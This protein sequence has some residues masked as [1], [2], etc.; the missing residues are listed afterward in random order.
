MPNE[1]LTTQRS[2]DIALSDAEAFKAML[3][4]FTEQW[5]IAGSVRRGSALVSDVDHV[6]VPKLEVIGGGGLFGDTP[7][8]VN[9]LWRELDRLV[10]H[11]P[12]SQEEDEFGQTE[13]DAFEPISKAVK[14]DKNGKA[15]TRWGMKL[16]SVHF[17]GFDHE[18]Y[19]TTPEAWGIAL[20]IRTGPADFSRHIV[21]EMQR[22]G[23]RAKDGIVE[24]RVG[25][26]YAGTSEP[27]WEL[28]AVPTERAVF[29]LLGV[30]YREPDQRR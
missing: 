19:T 6:V 21:T 25:G 16:R 14:T 1:T 20:L 9:L 18:I 3:L 10:D 8:T 7:D 2:R 28:V 22:H 4:P 5:T 26:D 15:S 12:D 29:D 17:R 11:K 23:Y 30:A 27:R 24:R 13:A